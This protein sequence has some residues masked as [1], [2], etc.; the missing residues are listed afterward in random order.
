MKFLSIFTI[1]LYF[2]VYFN[3]RCEPSSFKNWDY[4]LLAISNFLKVK[5]KKLGQEHY[6]KLK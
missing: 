4:N 2:E 6:A 5:P 3:Q 1:I